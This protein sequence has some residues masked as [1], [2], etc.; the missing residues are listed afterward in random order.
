M[1]AAASF[2]RDLGLDFP[3]TVKRGLGI[4]NREEH[5]ENL[6]LEFLEKNTSPS[7]FSGFELDDK[8]DGT[9]ELAYLVA[10]RYLKKPL[11]EFS[12]HATKLSYDLLKFFK[13]NAI[14]LHRATYENEA[15]SSYVF[16]YKN[17]FFHLCLG[18]KEE[19][20]KIT[21][22]G[23]SAYYLIENGLPYEDIIQFKEASK[24]SKPK[25]GI[26][27]SGR[28][29][30]YVSKLSLTT[31]QEFS[32]DH[33]NDDFEEFEKK[34]VDILSEKK[35]GL[36]LFH[37]E[38]GTGK[39]SAIRH[40]VEKVKRNFIF[41][42]PQMIS[43]L[44][45]PEFADIITDSHKGSVLILEDAE[46]ALMKR[47]SEDGFANSTLVSSVLNLTDGLYADLGQ[48]AIIATY[49]C[50]RNLIDPALLRKGRLKAEYKF[51]RLNKT[52]AQKLANK[53]GKDIDVIEDM[54]LAD[55]FNYEDQIS[56]N[57]KEEK[58]PIGFGFRS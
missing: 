43:H 11:S 23:L 10:A 3:S 14:C 5:I 30:M 15:D 27:K 40:L 19:D 26:I 1:Q 49:N 21:V 31:D 8:P 24:P 39:S 13:D 38:P 44:S 51:D 37:G 48:L 45:S 55:I 32:L 6:K 33:Y 36:F 22:T 41:I 42:P 57:E 52:K 47:E 17:A 28:G 9:W 18:C 25:I 56:N 7:E 50:D 12:F 58:R 29:G 54:T 35:P 46:K 4:F 20:E 16:L 53:I 34:L 2:M